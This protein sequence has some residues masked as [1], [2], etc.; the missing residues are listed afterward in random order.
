MTFLPFIHVRSCSCIPLTSTSVTASFCL[1]LFVPPYPH[2]T[3]LPSSLT[4]V[5]SGFSYSFCHISL[6]SS[7]QPQTLCLCLVPIFPLS[8]SP[9]LSTGSVCKMIAAFEL[10]PTPGALMKAAL[11]WKQRGRGTNCT[12]CTKQQQRTCLSTPGLSNVEVYILR[13]I[14]NVCCS[15]HSFNNHIH[16]SAAANNDFSY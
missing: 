11:R 13:L 15:P 16:T 5:S 1:L 6:L 3:S 12:L 4:L 14:C 10:L 2:S 8:L 9:L 7:P